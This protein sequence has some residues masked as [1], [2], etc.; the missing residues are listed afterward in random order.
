VATMSRHA[1]D[2]LKD[3]ALYKKFSAEAKAQAGKFDLHT[4]V[5]KYEALYEKFI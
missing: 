3:E 5:P 1:I 2:L 4:I